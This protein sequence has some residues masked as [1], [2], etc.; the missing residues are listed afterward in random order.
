MSHHFNSVDFIHVFEDFH[1]LNITV[2][3]KI[4][5]TCYLGVFLLR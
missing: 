2:I 4:R 3:V 1:G 5:Q